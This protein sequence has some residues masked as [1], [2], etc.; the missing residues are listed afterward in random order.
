LSIATAYFKLIIDVHPYD[1]RQIKIRQFYLPKACSNSG[2]I[3]IK[4]SAM[5]IW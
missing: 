4:Y 2:T 1:T 5:E 3:M